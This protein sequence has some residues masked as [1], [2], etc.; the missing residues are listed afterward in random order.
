MFVVQPNVLRDKSYDFAVHIV[1]FCRLLQEKREYILSK[2]LLRSGTSVGANIEEAL[3][4]QSK[5]DF[6][7]KLSISLKEA[8]ES[9]YW[10]RLINDTGYANLDDCEQLQQ[11]LQEVI[12][13]LVSIL[14]KTKENLKNSQ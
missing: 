9:R 10:I 6:I 3:Q 14:K 2:Q 11:E 5:Q 4:A 8:Y 7:A 1:I 12:A 13:L